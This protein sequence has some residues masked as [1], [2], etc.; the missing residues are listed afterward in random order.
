MLD[1]SPDISCKEQMSVNCAVALRV[2]ISTFRI[3]DAT[4]KHVFGFSEV[5][6]LQFVGRQLRLY[7]YR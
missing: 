4:L 3:G 7:T 2:N 1:W 5:K 6:Q